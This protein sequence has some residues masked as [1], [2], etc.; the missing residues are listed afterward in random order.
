[1][2]TMYSDK[3]TKRQVCQWV[4]LSESVYYYRPGAGR[5]GARPSTHT[6]KKSGECVDNGL[7]LEDIRQ[8]LSQEFCCYGYHNVTAELRGMDYIIN[9]KKVYR[10]MDE[11]HLLLGKV[12]RTT[13]K[14]E[15]VKHR[16][17]K[18]NYPLE[19]LC[20]DIKY[21]WVEGEKR[22]YYLLTII[23]V[24][25]RKVLG[26]IFQPSIRKID[27]INLF[28]NINNLYGIKGVTIRNDNGSQFIANQVKAFL[29]S[30]QAKQEFTHIA[31]PQE[32]AYIEAFH[33]IIDREVVQRF[34]FSSY[35]EAKITFEEHLCWY[36]NKRR[37]GQI[38]RIT[39]KEKWN[40]YFKT[41][42]TEI[43]NFEMPCQAKTGSAG[44]QP[45][46]NSM[47][48]EDNQ[49]GMAPVVPAYQTLSLLKMPQKTQPSHEVKDLNSCED[50]LQ[51]IGG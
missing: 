45:V 46:R 49:P 4:G 12:I 47:A 3:A 51:F 10:L 37:H 33:S 7:V 19:Y 42:S 6:L 31:T 44:E 11:N 26:Q 48:N 21:V 1:M 22:N 8:T 38:G 17:I 27:V 18:A 23:D 30:A 40:E 16:K 2:V 36:N 14:R 34:E 24:Y 29:I 15:F 9:H 32:N 39:P 50:F 35:Y 41:K 13:G 28:R 5:R 43:T 25:S 20:L